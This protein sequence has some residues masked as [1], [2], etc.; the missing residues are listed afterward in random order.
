MKTITPA[1]RTHLDGRVTTLATIWEITRTD[2]N[3]FFFTDHDADIAFDGDTYTAQTGYN[4]TSVANNVGLSVDNLDVEGVFDSA[5]ITEGDMRAGLFDYAEIKISLINWDDLTQGQLKQRRGRLGEVTV[6]QQGVFRAEL[7]GLAQQLS[8][9]IVSAYQA[10]CRADLGDSACKIVIFPSVLGR[11]QTVVVGDSYRVPT[12]TPTT[13]EWLGLVPNGSFEKDTAA[14]ALT[15]LEDWTVVT[16]SVD[17]YVTDE[18]LSAQSGTNYLR[19]GIVATAEIRQD[20]LLANAGLSTASIDAGNFTA[21]FSCYRA[22]N[23]VDDTGRVVVQFMDSD[24]NPVST[25]YD[26]AVEEITPVDTWVQRSASAVAVP[27]T[28]RYVRVRFIMAR[29]TGSDLN[30]CLDNVTLTLTDSVT[31]SIY[32]AIYENRVYTVTVAGTTNPTQPTYNTGIGS[33]TTEPDTAASGSVD[34][35]SGAAGSVDS[36]T[37][38]GVAIMSGAEAFDTDLSVTATNVAANVTAHS[39]SPNYT[40]VAVGASII[41]TAVTAGTG[42]NGFVVASTATTITTS[43]TNLSGG[44]TGPSLVASNAFMRDG[45]IL[46]VIDQKTFTLDVSEARAVDDWFNGGAIA[47]ESGANASLVVEVRGWDASSNT[48]SL[49]L[50]LPFELFSGLKVRLYPGC[51]KRIAICNS[52]FAN[53]IN[54]RGEPYVPGQDE[55]TNYPDAR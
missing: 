26:S 43:D 49:F 5:D 42:P 30:A 27:A 31:T 38:D 18:G 20:I 52:R 14:T 1:L 11:A 8:Q 2:G 51:D 55:L 37:V 12:A 9:N 39:S 53:V 29:V 47:I 6:T 10:E 46:D 17:V 40:A 34:L 24:L 23:D 48:V 36:I 33:T 41:I 15:E 4:R 44:L 35:T 7:R 3:Q 32:Q 28:A 25:M 13:T 50:P 21:D 16:G 19:G 45:T 22:N 54:F